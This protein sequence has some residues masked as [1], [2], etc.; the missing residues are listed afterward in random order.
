MRFY[1]GLI[2]LL[3]IG[4]VAPAHAGHPAEGHEIEGQW[5]DAY[6]FPPA[7]LSRG[8]MTFMPLDEYPDFE[9]LTQLEKYM[10][11]GVK[12]S[13]LR[14]DAGLPPYLT[15][16]FTWVTKFYDA[17]GYIPEQLDLDTVRMIPGKINT[18][19]E[20]LEVEK[21]PLTGE[22]PRLLEKELS[23]GNFYFKV[24]SAEDIDY[25]A[26]NGYTFIKYPSNGEAVMQTPVF[27][28]RMYGHEGVLENG[29]KF[30][31]TYNCP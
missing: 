19:E 13:D 8:D 18:P 10:V 14:S 30:Y 29:F 3:I 17:H 31:A 26:E 27:Y 15:T 6:R 28:V 20:W 4:L 9:N 11:F 5:N 24:L 7:E 16:I 22:W 25:F 23:P 1:F 2:V 12:S 21:N